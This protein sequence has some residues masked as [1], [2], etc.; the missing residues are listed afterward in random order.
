MR[1][2]L[3]AVAASIL[4]AGTIPLFADDIPYP[5]GGQLAPAH[6]FT[7]SVTG[8]LIGYFAGSEA[9]GND[10]I[11][12][13]DTTQNT[14]SGFFNSPTTVRQL[15]CPQPFSPSTPETTS[16][17]S[18]PTTAQARSMTPSTTEAYRRPSAPMDTT[19]PTPLHIPAASL[20]FLPALLALTSV[21]KT[22][23]LL[24]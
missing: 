21:W 19:M 4:A 18:S 12:L 10:T 5:N 13:W 1:L 17:L 16:S 6:I 14:F 7:A 11:E 3:V 2:A 20:D 24:V 22:S 23:L 15:V 8:S 9:G